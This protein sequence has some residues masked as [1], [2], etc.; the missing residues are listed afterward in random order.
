MTSPAALVLSIPLLAA[1]LISPGG[2][3]CP[4]D[5]LSSEAVLAANAAFE[6]A[7]QA[8]DTAALSRLVAPDYLFVTSSGEVRD[9]HELLRSYGAREVHLTVFRSDSAHVRLRPPV[10]ILNAIV[11][12]VGEYV[13]G[14]RTGTIITGSYR[15][16]R[17][18]VCDASGWQVVS[19]HE[20]RLAEKP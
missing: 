12:K 10:A 13:A 2:A 20:S 15:F 4:Q 7:A 19:S 16:T 8:S 6:R 18:Y 3:R 17:V 1:V 14:P 9:R 5:A 11:R